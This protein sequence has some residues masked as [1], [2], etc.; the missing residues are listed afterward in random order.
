M[1]CKSCVPNPRI[2]P[3]NHNYINYMNTKTVLTRSPK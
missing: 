1:S 3:E 2:T